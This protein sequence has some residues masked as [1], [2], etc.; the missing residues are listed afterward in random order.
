MTANA[1]PTA[2]GIILVQMGA[3]T[4]GQLKTVL[5]Y[6]RTTVL[7][8]NSGELF[9]SMG[10]CTQEDIDAALEVQNGFRS[11]RLAKQATAAATVATMRKRT[12][13]KE[14]TEVVQFGKELVKKMGVD[15]TPTPVFGIEFPAI[16]R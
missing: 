12:T 13:A 10:F 7:K 1:D 4:E 9:V 14:R 5:D 15:F 8:K 3:I 16:K 6:Q 2:I 11:D